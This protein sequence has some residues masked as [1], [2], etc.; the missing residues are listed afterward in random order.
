MRHWRADSGTAH[1]G[2]DLDCDV[3]LHPVGSVA[4]PN[5]PQT[6]FYARYGGRCSRNRGSQQRTGTGRKLSTGTVL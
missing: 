6:P 3:R 5:L 1:N 2:C 4:L